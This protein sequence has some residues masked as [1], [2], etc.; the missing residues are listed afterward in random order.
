MIFIVIQ[1]LIRRD[2][3]NFIITTRRH[4]SSRQAQSSS[5]HWFLTSPMICVPKEFVPPIHLA[6][7]QLRASSFPTNTIRIVLVPPTKATW[8]TKGPIRHRRFGS[9]KSTFLSSPSRWR[10]QFNLNVH[11]QALQRSFQDRFLSM[12]VFPR[13]NLIIA[14][15]RLI[16]LSH[17]HQTLFGNMFPTFEFLFSSSPSLYQTTQ[18]SL[19]QLVVST[20]MPP[21]KLK[22]ATGASTPPSGA[23]PPG[24]PVSLSYSAAVS[25]T[26]SATP[27]GIGTVVP[28]TSLGVP[29]TGPTLNAS[30]S[31]P[32]GTASGNTGSVQISTSSPQTSN[33]LL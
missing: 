4:N 5:Q 9:N 14:Y 11:P 21:K 2:L 3:Q 22:K 10:E 30:V 26:P 33:E 16:A 28:S 8:S 12:Y 27:V 17:D 7:E 32:T 18:T 20:T 6:F 23:T 31:V 1:M 19:I 25:G 24:T 15:P 13:S 29:P